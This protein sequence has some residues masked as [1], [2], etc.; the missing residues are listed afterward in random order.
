MKRKLQPHRRVVR[1]ARNSS[2]PLL[3]SLS[4]LHFAYAAPV[5][6]V[7]TRN[8]AI[9]VEAT[10]VDKTITGKVTDE[11][12]NGL[13]GVSIVIKGTQKGTVTDANGQFRLDVPEKATLVLSFVGYEPQEVLVGNQNV[14]NLTMKVDSKVL[15][16]IVVIGYGTLKKFRTTAWRRADSSRSSSCHR[17][18]RSR[19]SGTS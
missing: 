6:G 2:A 3:L 15:E 8:H 4:C 19:T 17:P 13:P 18:C 9:L 1:M 10:A 7:P 14:L 16:E 5:A 12:N 11:T